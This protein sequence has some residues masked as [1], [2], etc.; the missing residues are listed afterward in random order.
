MFKYKKNAACSSVT[1][2]KKRIICLK[3]C[4]DPDIT[5][6]KFK[7]LIKQCKMNNSMI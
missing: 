3:K 1:V 4:I 5:E 2:Y 7:V 6:S